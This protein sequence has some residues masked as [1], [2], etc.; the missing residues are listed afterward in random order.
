MHVIQSLRLRLAQ[1]KLHQ[2]VRETANR[3]DIVRFRQ[4][5]EEQMRL[6][7]RMARKAER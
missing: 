2:L 3:P 7:M 4:K 5:R 6:G 1:R